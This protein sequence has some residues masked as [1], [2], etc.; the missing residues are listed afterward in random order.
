M[1]KRDDRKKVIANLFDVGFNA[2][3]RNTPIEDKASDFSPKN[4]LG[5]QKTC[6]KCNIQFSVMKN[7]EER[8]NPK[9]DIIGEIARKYSSDT[10]LGGKYVQKLQYK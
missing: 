5:I 1:E 2:L 3:E 6:Q 9:Y 4:M 7:H 10:A 8:N